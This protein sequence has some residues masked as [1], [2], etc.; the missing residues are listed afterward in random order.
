[1]TNTLADKLKVVERI[2]FLAL[3]ASSSKVPML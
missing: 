2:F 3:L 1:L